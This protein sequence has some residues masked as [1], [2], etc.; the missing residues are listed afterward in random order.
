[1]KLTI[2]KKMIL[3]TGSALLGI[4]LLVGLGQL[5]MNKV[6][7]AANY[8]NVNSVPSILI[9]NRLGQNFNDYQLATATHILNTDN[10]TMAEIETGI[11][12]WHDGIEKD[13][14]AYEKDGCLGASCFSDDKDKQLLVADRALAAEYF[15]AN[16]KVLALSRL[17]KNDQARDLL[18]KNK[19]LGEKFKQ[20]L[21]AHMKY[22]EELA[23]K[24]VDDAVAAKSASLTLSLIIAA[25]TL[26]TV[27][28]LGFFITR[29]I[30][31]PLGEVVTAAN[32]MTAGDFN[33]KLDINSKDEVGL[34][35]N[36][37]RG[38]QSAVQAMTADAV[39]LAKAAV[40]GKL[41]T[42]ADASKHQG[43]F[44]GIV[45]GVNDTLDA[46]IGPLNVA[47]GYV[48]RIAKGE[49]PSKITDTYNGDFNTLKNNLNACIDAINAQA[50][51]AQG[52]A[53]GNLS[54]AINVRGES[55]V[56]A[57]SLV[58][59]TKVLQSLQNEL[60]RL[61]VAS[62]DGLLSERGKPEQ[63]KGAY[64]DVIVGVNQ[65]L[66]AILLP[67]G[68]GNRVL[69]LIRGGNLRERVEIAC[70][71]DHEKMKQ[72]INGVHAW[73]SELVA[74]VT[75]ISNGD[76]TV[77]MG[78]ASSD[79]QIHEFLMLLKQNIQN[80]VTDT[81][82]LSKAALAGK[83]ETRADASKHQG[84]FYKVIAGTN[85]TLDVVVDKLEWYRSII[86]AVPFPIHVIDL[87]MKW[88]YLNKAFE[89]L[90]VERGYVRDR[91]DAVGRAC[92]TANANICNTKNCGIMQL[93]SGV[94]ESFF[95]W[96][97]LKCKQ[98]TANV[99]NAKGEAVGYVETV[100]DLSAT[101]G[102][103]SYTEKEVQRVAMNLERLSS[104]DLNLDLQ[105]QDADQYTLEVKTQFGKINK[106]FQQVGVSLNALVTDATML[107]EAAVGGKLATRA[108]ASKHHG[109]YQKIVK[110][111]NDTLDAVIGPLNVAA[112]YVDRISK[113]DIP[114]KIT[115]TYN[116]DFN[117][118]KN[119]LN[120]CVDSVNALVADA[121]LLAKA[122]VD[123]RLA[124]RADASKH[125]GDFQKVVKGVNDTLDAVIGPLNVAAGYVDRISKGDIPAKITDTYNGDFNVLKNNLNTCVDSVN[126]LV[127]DANLLAK[128]AVD[129]KLATRADASKHQGDFQKVVAGVNSTLDAVINPLNVAAGYVDRIAKGETPAKI[130]DTYNGDFNV[131]KNN[132]NACIDAINA[133]ATAAQG[134][135]AGDFSVAINVRCEADVVAKSLVGITQV[136]LSLQA[137]LLRLTAASKEGLLSER[138]KPNQFKGAYA[139]VVKGVNE[140]LDAILLPIGE[141]NRI[142]A[143]ISTGKIDELIT[144][145]YKGDHEKMKQAI[146]NVAKAVNALAGDANLLSKAA[147]DGKLDTRADAAKHQGDYRKVVDG[148]NDVMV[149]VNTP[150][151]ELRTV[152]GALEG[153]DL[154]LSM[155]KNYAGTWDDLKSAVNNML[156]K[157]TDVVTDVNSGAQALASA[158]EEVSATAQS[159]S[160]AASEQAAGV[161][162][163]SA[164]IE[165]MTS[166]IA[167]N[168]E[169]AKITDG[170]ASKAAKDATDG[171]E[172]VNATV[173]AMKQ[174]AKK[175][176]IIDDIAAQTN[177][178]ALNA[179][180]EAARAG[181]H[182]KGFAV[183]AAEVRKLAERSQVAAQE[184]G[185]VASS[186]VELA[187]KAGRLLAEIVPNIR[188]TSD[189][190]QEITAASTEQSSGV[191][192]INS[193]VSQ[194]SQTTQ[195]NASSSE[196]LAATSEE[197]SGQ[198]EQLQQTMAFF[199]LDAGARST[200][201]VASPRKGAASR[202]GVGGK[203]AVVAVATHPVQAL[204]AELDEAQ[205]TK[206]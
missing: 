110:G 55:D 195:Q 45:K 139:D 35:A 11:K 155:K 89:K 4:L 68:E 76:M 146:N 10:A 21:D 91:Q 13:V 199:K 148:L 85:G 121:N 144:Q 3:L 180:I 152:L 175:I 26:G 69:G 161:E 124:T 9:M 115:D 201:Y 149:A 78:K 193:A 63:F 7:D 88:T 90:M 25:L 176:G 127:A 18:T 80:L 172:A 31:R 168:T 20:A 81:N 119:N 44:Q 159:L 37:V 198:A 15:A 47:A 162:E 137:E 203:R 132:L 122:A 196:E 143:Q 128:A 130:T 116:G 56:V 100:T 191:G 126:A 72:A 82:M 8:G 133:Q 70:K 97:N 101:L 113:G 102:V 94:K 74:Y 184:I 75:K 87:D 103:K 150:V 36:A 95:D 1:M 183:V 192:Q 129:G 12:A 51:A 17:N 170:M 194:L 185:E 14:N 79:D 50:A 58:G 123:G 49:T 92:S 177:L 171:G 179:A 27:S 2:V 205:F 38:L 187:E 54:V 147:V 60:Q 23:K 164:S 34:L 42:R 160:Q 190:V 138:G 96:G 84:D 206:F 16:D 67:I 77:T 86:D 197:M 112:G 111:V 46:V 32:R 83:F 108:D 153:G 40:E 135:A 142:L 145:T 30:V 106:S 114:A 140:M 22:N 33:F 105:T 151:E 117:T 125:Q 107:S 6:F 189:L 158:S 104:G 178:L 66:D 169:N 57:K 71:G 93:K 186:S 53:D 43:D 109:D 98:D 167:Q 39:L 156:K 99:L 48:D 19:T 29:S 202:S 136:L 141:G 28:I 61:T 41:A 174:I 173:E 118:L 134:I 52:I 157:L 5:Q 165:Q 73:L 24:G 204:S 131:L 65:M 181:E 200:A 59:I 182:G 120:T 188:K 163:T 64:A 154:T 62:K 166:S